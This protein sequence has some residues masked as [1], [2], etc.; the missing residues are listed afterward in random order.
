MDSEGD[1]RSDSILILVFIQ[2]MQWLAINGHKIGL[3]S[4]KN[5]SK[6]PGACLQH[7]SS[8]GMEQ[9]AT[10]CLYS[11]VQQHLCKHLKH[12]ILQILSATIP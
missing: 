5:V 8:Q 11:L 7:S 9:P 10:A 2:M 3:P 4:T 6:V 1:G 12:F